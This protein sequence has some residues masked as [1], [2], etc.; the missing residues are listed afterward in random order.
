LASVLSTFPRAIT[1]AATFLPSAKPAAT[2][3]G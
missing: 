3:L 1:S 2:S